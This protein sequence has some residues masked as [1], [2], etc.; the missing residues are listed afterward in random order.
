MADNTSLYTPVLYQRDYVENL[1][2]GTDPD[3]AKNSKKNPYSYYF[4]T[5]S[6]LFYLRKKWCNVPSKIISRKAWEKI[7][8]CWRLEGQGR[9]LQDPDPYQTVTGPQHCR[10]PYQDSV[11]QSRLR[12]PNSPDLEDMSA[13]PLCGGARG[14]S[15]KWKGL[16]DGQVFLQLTFTL[17]LVIGTI[18]AIVPVTR[19]VFTKWYVVKSGWPNFAVIVNWARNFLMLKFPCIMSF[20]VPA[21]LYL[22][23]QARETSRPYP[24]SV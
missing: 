16:Y 3:Q 1:V 6:W 9:K 10:E 12:A 17:H 22:I 20:P 2:R 13:K 19:S 7:V 14:I 4:V 23:S 24:R 8:F 11:S 15:W 5:S 18:H 21:S